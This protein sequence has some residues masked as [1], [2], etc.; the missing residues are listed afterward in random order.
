MAVVA[1]ALSLP[2]VLRS[3]VQPGEV[4]LPFYWLVALAVVALVPAVLVRSFMGSA[5]SASL[6]A[7]LGLLYVLAAADLRFYV[8]LWEPVTLLL[9]VAVPEPA[10]GLL[11]LVLASCAASGAIGHILGPR[12][13][14]PEVEVGPP[15]V[16]TPVQVT[17]EREGKAPET[18][19]PLG[20]PAEEGK[21]AAEELKLEPE[22][23]PEVVEETMRCPDCGAEIPKDVRFCPYCGRS[24]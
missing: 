6:G 7:L 19:P 23:P 20:G 4:A 8:G 12:A 16:A 15:P 21:A 14:V 24:F 18:A 9:A 13:A 5:G 17:T 11:M 22:A 10:L 1:L 3:I 2:A